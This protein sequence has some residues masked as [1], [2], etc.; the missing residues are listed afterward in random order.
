LSLLKEFNLTEAELRQLTQAVLLIAGAGDR[1][2]P[3]VQEAERLVNILPNTKLA[4]LPDSG[5]ACLLEHNVNLYKI[6]RDQNFVEHHIPASQE[7]QN[8]L[9]TPH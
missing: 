1:L 5:H 7:I 9:P 4:V 3:S 8:Q 2:L 6:L